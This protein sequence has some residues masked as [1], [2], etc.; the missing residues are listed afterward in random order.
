[1]SEQIT[2][3]WKRSSSIKSILQ[4]IVIWTATTILI[5]LF[6]NTGMGKVMNHIVFDT[7][8]S[9]QPLPNWSKPILSYVLPVL[10]LGT[11]CLLF[12]DHTRRWGL[13]TG[14]ILMTAYSVYAYLAYIEFYGYVVCACGKIFEKMSWQQHFYFNTA[15][16]SVSILA[17]YMY[18]RLNRSKK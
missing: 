10:E 8:L 14:T 12:N 7:Q 1:M 13:W 15:I 3:H 18:Y 6:F 16:A 17:L 2:Y 11:L 5:I 9:R 4:R